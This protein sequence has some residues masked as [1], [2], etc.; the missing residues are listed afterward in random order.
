MRKKGHLNAAFNPS[1]VGYN[2]PFMTALRDNSNLFKW[3]IL[4]D[5]KGNSK[6]DIVK[7]KKLE[8]FYIDKYRTYIGY[9][10]CKGY[11]ATLGGDGVSVIG[12]TIYRMNSLNYTIKEVYKSRKDVLRA[13]GTVVSVSTCCCT[14][15]PTAYGDVWYYKS[16]FDSLSNDEIVKDIDYR[17]NKIYYLNSE[18][19][20]IKKFNDIFEVVSFFNYDFPFIFQRKDNALC[21]ANDFYN[22]SFDKGIYYRE[23]PVVQFDLNGEFLRFFESIHEAE[24]ATGVKRP[25][26]IAVCERDKITAG[27]SQWR[28]AHDTLSVS[29]VKAGRDNVIQKVSQYDIEGNYIR[30]F[31][32]ITEAMRLTGVDASTIAKVCRGK[33]QTTK[34]YR[35]QYGDSKDKLSPLV[36]YENNQKKKIYLKTYEGEEIVFESI[37]DA[38]RKVGLSQSA[39][40][41]YCKQKV[42]QPILGYWCF[43]D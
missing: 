4:E 10:D 24:R 23:K 41:K 30:T 25:S 11:N 19:E 14:T 22:D 17:V 6:N 12:E 13:F 1:N 42:K 9:A 20:I 39:I 35:W 43:I 37:A 29:K 3:S 5:T 16:Y 40:S 36:I 28:Y 33:K 27:N 26:I 8:R 34:G 31:E 15:R 7:L 2:R 38:S 32:S 18:K 21:F